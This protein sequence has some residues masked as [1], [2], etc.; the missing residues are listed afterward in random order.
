MTRG[1]FLRLGALLGV[2]VGP[3]ELLQLEGAAL[4]DA[5]AIGAGEAAGIEHHAG[6]P[7]RIEAG[8]RRL[9]MR[10]IGQAHGAD[11]AV[12]PGLL[13][14]P[15]AGVVA[16]RPLGEVLRELALRAVAAAAI[17]VDHDVAGAH[18]MRPRPRP[19]VIGWLM[20]GSISERERSRLAVGRPLQDAPAAA[21]R[22]RPP[23]DGRPVDVGRE[24]N[25][26]AHPHHHVAMHDDVVGDDLDRGGG[27]PRTAR[28]RRSLGVPRGVAIRSSPRLA[29]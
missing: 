14:D 22:Q 29:T 23:A 10:R 9:R 6:E 13:D 4:A 25:A 26:V 5:G 17:L 18:E 3:G 15:G 12:A 28:A 11:L 21:S 16:V 19:R 20:P 8:E 7:G 27:A 2:V 24:L 1:S